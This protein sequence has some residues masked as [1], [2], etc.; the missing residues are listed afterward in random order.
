M[1]DLIHLVHR[2]RRSPPSQAIGPI[3]G[4]PCPLLRDERK[5][6]TSLSGEPRLMH[7]HINH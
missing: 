7:L 1:L 5:E 3:A 6:G 2:A 4:R